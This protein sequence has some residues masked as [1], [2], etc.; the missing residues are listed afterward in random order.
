M[1]DTFPWVQ[2]YMDL[3]WTPVR[4]KFKEKQP[5]DNAW[6]S[7]FPSAAHAERAFAGGPWNV[8][9]AL[10]KPSAGVTDVDLD[11]MET[12][13]LAPYFLP[14]TPWR[15]GRASKPNSHWLYICSAQSS[16][17]FADNNKHLTKK[18]MLVEIRSTGGQTVVPPSVHPSGEEIQWNPDLDFDQGPPTVDGAVLNRA[19]ARIALA[20]FFLRRF[21]DQ[22]HD[23]RLAL[24]GWLARQGWLEN[25]V[26]H[27]VSTLMRVRGHGDE[28]V[29]SMVHGTYERLANQD[30]NMPVRGLNACREIFQLSSADIKQAYQWE[31]KAAPAG[32]NP[33]RAAYNQTDGGVSDRF[34]M[35]NLEYFRFCGQ[36]NCWYVY[37]NG[38]W[39]VDKVLAAQRVMQETIKEIQKESVTFRAADDEDAQVAKKRA[40]KWALSLESEAHVRSCLFLTRSHA[41]VRINEFDSDPWVINAKNGVIDLRDGGLTPHSPERMMT[42]MLNVVYDPAAKA[43]RFLKFLEEI[44]PDPEIRVFLQTWFGYTLTG[45]S[46]E[47]VFPIFWGDGANGKSTLVQLWRDMLGTYATTVPAETVIS[48]G[49]ST[50]RHPAD[51]ARLQ[52]KRFACISETGQNRTL[53]EAKVKALTGGDVIPVRGMRE[54]WWDLEPSHKLVMLTN[55]RPQIQG[56]DGGIW[57]RITLVPFEVSYEGREDLFLRDALAAESAGVLNWALEGLQRWRAEKLRRPAVVLT[58]TAGYRKEQDLIE[59]F[60]QDTYVRDPE[61][62]ISSETLQQDYMVWCQV[63]NERPLKGRALGA[64]LK[65]KKLSPYRGDFRGWVGLKKKIRT[66]HVLTPASAKQGEKN[67]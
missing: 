37:E 36:R 21:P 24:T 35:D 9:I 11:A 48:S 64:V 39:Q 5:T 34:L 14:P 52:G 57:R 3:G 8:G 61:A 23:A 41:P 40:V 33:F 65:S 32:A 31:R 4:V 1:S 53:D 26:V 45:L 10:G 44:L 12:I 56:Q 62:K 46:V 15:F 29:D 2:G 38:C 17:G 22:G 28:D 7:G 27:F 55:H 16:Q 6:G 30:S 13:D 63:N 18:N 66:L 67:G 60:L 43:T 59:L 20:S 50:E 19:V 58:F 42:G 49:A 25:D 47:H 51:L 54:D